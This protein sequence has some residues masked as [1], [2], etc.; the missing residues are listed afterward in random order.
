[1]S[2]RKKVAGAGRLSAYALSIERRGEGA[3]ACS[4][5]QI[6]CFFVV[7]SVFL[8]T[9]DTRVEAGK[10]APGNIAWPLLEQ[11]GGPTCTASSLVIL[12][13]ESFTA[14]LFA[15]THHNSFW[16]SRLY[17]ICQLQ[18]AINSATST[19]VETYV[20]RVG[21]C[22]LHSKEEAASP[23]TTNVEEFVAFY[24]LKAR[25]FLY[26]LKCF[27]NAFPGSYGNCIL[28]F[29]VP[30]SHKM[31]SKY[32]S[33][34]C[35]HIAYL[36]LQTCCPLTIFYVSVSTTELVLIEAQNCPMMSF[37]CFNRFPKCDSSS[38]GAALR[39][40]SEKIIFWKIKYFIPIRIELASW[41]ITSQALRNTLEAPFSFHHNYFW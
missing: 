31:L 35:S 6:L 32:F 9:K 15:L 13:F 16:I 24:S 20:T 14:P 22:W 33:L 21:D 29:I 8:R 10:E 27:E 11:E 40:L 12:L 3:G 38:R 37:L 39:N 2:L 4:S 1:M 23:V 28:L 25:S 36:P 30:L 5:L 41:F 18:P 26:P 34:L 19:S 17:S 7:N